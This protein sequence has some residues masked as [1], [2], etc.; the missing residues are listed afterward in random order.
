[1]YIIV[2]LG[3]PEQKY[4]G[5]RHNIGFSAITALCDHYNISLDRREH[6]AVCGRGYIEGQKVLLAE[7]QT[8]MNLSGD[9]VR[10]LV[11]YYKIDPE[12]ELIVVYDDI[13]LA[14]GRLRI[15]EKGSAGGHNGIKNIIARLGT[16]NFKRIRIG[17][18][19]KPKGWDLADYVLGRFSR[20]EE[21]EIREALG[22][23][24][25]ACEIMLT[26]DVSAAMTRFN[27]S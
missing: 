3:N 15:R 18:G 8:Y 21:P 19:E 7:P 5:T 14:P 2:G 26:E 24:V 25:E 4:A 9:S 13:N 10:A 22:R 11:D 1:M 20:E 6:K 17:V 16:Q 27:G 12:Q 23:V